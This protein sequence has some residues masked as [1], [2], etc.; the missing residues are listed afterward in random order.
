VLLCAAPHTPL[1]FMG[2]EY[3][4]TRP[5]C[6]FTSHPEPALAAAV[7]EGRRQEF[8]AFTAFADTDVPDPQDPG[9]FA[10]SKLD[11]ATASTPDGEARRA[12]WTDLLHLRRTH[13]ALGNGR[14]DLVEVLH[15]ADEV[16]AVVR[17]DPDAA[18]VLLVVNLGEESHSIA[19]PGQGWALLFASDEPQYGGDAQTAS[20]QAVPPHTASLWGATGPEQRHRNHVQ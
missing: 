1:L 9:T 4:E 5:F 11:W 19:A 2:E 15:A 20:L 7:S 8:A 12:V 14:R 3:G 10:R 16:V 17:H 18:P 6:Y 13:P